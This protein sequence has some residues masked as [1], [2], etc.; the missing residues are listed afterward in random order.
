MAHEEKKMLVL[1]ELVEEFRTCQGLGSKFGTKSNETAEILNLEHGR[2]Q[3]KKHQ[4]FDES[5]NAKPQNLN[6]NSSLFPKL[7]QSN[8]KY[9]KTQN[10]PQ[11]IS[12]PN[13]KP[14]QQSTKNPC[15]H[16]FLLLLL[17]HGLIHPYPKPFQDTKPSP[18][19][20]P[21]DNSLIT[22]F[23]GC[24]WILRFDKDDFE[25]IKH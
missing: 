23:N 25:Q 3:W 4:R 13:S 15:N 10:P 8:S 20:S 17:A 24:G 22:K 11:Q 9:S 6:F 14:K 18:L 5:P 19:P 1:E 16:N 7:N 2:S 12:L 21:M